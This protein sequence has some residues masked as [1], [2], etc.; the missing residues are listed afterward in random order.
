MKTD[1]VLHCSECEKVLYVG[2]CTNC[3]SGLSSQNTF[4]KRACSRCG[5]KVKLENGVFIC[6]VCG[7]Q[8]YD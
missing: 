3:G 8:H 5:S 1:E 4:I 7:Q 6:S 2:F